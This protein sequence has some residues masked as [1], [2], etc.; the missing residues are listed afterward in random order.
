M[1]NRST[2]SSGHKAPTF[3]ST[4]SKASNS[5]QTNK[6]K[7]EEEE[8]TMSPTVKKE[9]SPEAMDHLM[10]TEEGPTKKKRKSAAGRSLIRWD[11]KYSTSIKDLF[12]TNISHHSRKG[13]APPIGSRV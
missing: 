8:A 11:C 13:S 5:V 3:R 9:D 1:H 4:T 2:H 10:L 12:S 6:V 7:K